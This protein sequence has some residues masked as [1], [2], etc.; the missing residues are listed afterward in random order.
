MIAMKY[1]SIGLKAT[2]Y[3]IA[4]RSRSIIQKLLYTKSRSANL[5][6]QKGDD[7]INIIKLIIALWFLQFLGE[8]TKQA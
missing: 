8:L 2:L 6:M 5:D 3:P 7:E 4:F 1:I